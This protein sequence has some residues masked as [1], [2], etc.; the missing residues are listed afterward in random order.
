[1][2]KMTAQE[3]AAYFDYADLHACTSTEQMQKHCALCVEYGFKMVA[4]NSYW[5]KACKEFVKDSP[6]H[7]GGSTG[8]PLGLFTL[9]T[10]L[11][12]A[13]NAIA[14]GT[15]EIDYV[16]N[17]SKLKDGDWAYIEEEMRQ[18]VS[19]CREHNLISKAIIE[20]CYLTEEEIIHMC[21]IA[22]RVKPSFLKTSTGMAAGGATIEAV[23]LMRHHLDDGIQVK[24]S[25]GIRDLDTA[26]A[27]IEAGATRLGSSSC[28]AIMEAYKETLA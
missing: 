24:A 4:V 2:K 17:L 18:I 20:I 27:M 3:L 9:E 21:Q 11:A 6:V 19:L 23:R 22:N 12:E 15:D 8:F 7:V 26:L 10:K 14:D 1:M 25:G 28:V 5:V 13:R 16:I